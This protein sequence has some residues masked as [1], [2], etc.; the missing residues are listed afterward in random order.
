M[1]H[2][3]VVAFVSL[4]LVLGVALTVKTDLLIPGCAQR[5]AQE[6]GEFSESFSSSFEAQTVKV[7]SLVGEA[8]VSISTEVGHR[9]GSSR[10]FSFDDFGDD[11]F[12]KFFEEFFGSLPERQFKRQGLGSG[13]IISK[14]GY[15]LTNEHVVAGADQI[16]VRL[17]DGRKF[18]AEVKG[19]DIRSD[20]AV[21]KIKANDLPV[22]ELGDSD[23]LKTGQWVM[24]A[25]N[26]FGFAIEGAEPTVTAGVISALHRDLPVLERRDRSYGNLIQTDAAINPGN[27]GGPLVNMKGEVIGINVAMITT[28]GGYQGLGFAIPINK[29]KKIVKKL[30][31]GEEI[32]YGW[33]GVSIQ[34]LNDDLKN[35]LGL[36]DEKGVIVI[37]VF[38]GSPAAK[39]GLKEGD[40]ILT[41]NGRKL[42]KVNE[43][44]KMVSEEEPGQSAIVGILRDNKS[45]K[46]DVMLGKRPQDLEG[47]A[48]EETTTTTVGFRGLEVEEVSQELANRYRIV[49][50]VGVVVTYVEPDSPADEAGII[51][52]DIVTNVEGRKIQNKQDFLTAVKGV[53]G[54]CLI[55]TNRGFFVVKK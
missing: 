29:A 23:N 34:N 5:S 15:I 50:Q 14:E 24:A 20:L 44:V 39:A 40:L 8:V 27:S 49:G 16:Q 9:L 55:K 35:Y 17:S 11:F 13:V 42:S 53:K 52:S 38:N 2:W 51:P 46:L 31:K 32:L 45:M 26:P 21:I 4:G 12:R 47:L 30:I 41:F 28:T 36:K 37:K 48:D 33:L 25:G 1:R 3:K 18:N 22:A 43:L 6:P 19:K 7:A 54:D 10:Q